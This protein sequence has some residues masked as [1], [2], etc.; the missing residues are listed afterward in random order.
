MPSI[1]VLGATGFIGNALCAELLRSG[2]HQVWGVA[3]TSKKAVQLAAQEVTPILCEDPVEKPEAWIDVVHTA[4]I[5][6]VVDAAGANAGSLKFLSAIKAAGAKRL[7][8]A[9]ANGARAPKLGFL[10]TSGMWVQGSSYEKV[11]DTM[12]VGTKESRSQPPRMVM[13]RPSWEQT[14]LAAD[15]VLDVMIVRPALVYGRGSWVWGGI[16]GPL[17]GAAHAKLDSVKIAVKPDTFAGLVH[18]DDLASGMRAAVEKLPLIAGTGVYPVFDM[19]TSFES[20]KSIVEASAKAYGINGKVELTDPPED[21]VY[22]E[23]MGT[24]LNGDSGR[25]MQLLGWQPKIFGMM[26][27]VEVYAKAFAAAQEYAKL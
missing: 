14:V 23:A 9:K 21:N 22:M 1:L 10:Y 4:R 2:G 11:S 5:D 17:L 18:V 27:G 13:Q 8:D 3:R 12:P 7:D 19:I 6:V 25:A 20:M 15:D 16:F 24:S 26:Q